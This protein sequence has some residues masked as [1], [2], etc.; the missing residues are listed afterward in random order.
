[1]EY[2]FK[3]LKELYDRIKPALT[4]KKSEFK[5]IGMPYISEADIWNYLTKTKWVNAKELSLY[6]MVSDVFNC[7]C[8]DVF[9]CMIKNINQEERKPDFN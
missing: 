2:E 1:M 9:N 3:T 7:K 8:D 6:Q 5:K 4:S